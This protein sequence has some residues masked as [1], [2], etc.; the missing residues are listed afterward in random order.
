MK[1]RSD[2]IRHAAAAMVVAAQ[3]LTALVIVRLGPT[4][5]IPMHFDAA[6]QVNRWGDRD[7]AARL[8]LLMAALSAV[9]WLGLGAMSRR[10]DA[11]PGREQG[12]LF[13]QLIMFAITS[14]VCALAL[15]LT[16]GWL[17]N[18]GGAAGMAILCGVLALVGAYLGKMS[19]NALVGVRTPWTYASRLAWDRSN[20]LAGR[21]FFWGGLAGL[22]AAPLAPQPIGMQATVAGVMLI[23]ALAVFESWRV[24]RTDPDRRSVF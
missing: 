8:V 18:A 24:W 5:P 7:E 11:P 20:R 15:A 19:P 3:G 21:L 6:G 1:T 14:A 22:V 16:F 12:L 4:H 13:S 23:A 2:L 17:A 10:R 9:T